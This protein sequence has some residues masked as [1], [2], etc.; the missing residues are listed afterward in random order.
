MVLTFLPLFAGSQIAY[1][2]Y[3]VYNKQDNEGKLLIA[4][5]APLIGVFVKVI[6]RICVQRLY[7]VTHPGIRVYY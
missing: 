4:L 3:P 5:F 2:L 1:H 7:N 6:S